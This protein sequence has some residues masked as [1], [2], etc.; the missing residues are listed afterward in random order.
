V[1]PVS[2]ISRVSV[3]KRGDMEKFEDRIPLCP[4]CDR[5]YTFT[6]TK[7]EIEAGHKAKVAPVRKKM[8]QGT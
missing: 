2:N 1:L 8:M 5:E 4:Q 3:L 6:I 7:H